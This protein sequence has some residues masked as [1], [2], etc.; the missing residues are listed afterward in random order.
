MFDNATNLGYKVFPPISQSIVEVGDQT[1]QIGAV[2]VNENL[3]SRHRSSGSS[4][5]CDKAD[6]LRH[7]RH[8][9]GDR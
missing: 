2:A 5:L 7:A 4:R 3:L 8:L 9:M 6:L 1:G